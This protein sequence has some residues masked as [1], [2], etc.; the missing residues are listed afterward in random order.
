[1]IIVESTDLDKAHIKASL[2]NDEL[3]EIKYTD[4]MQHQRAIHTMNIC[5]L[6]QNL[7]AY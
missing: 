1:M 6:M 3:F 5:H 4:E 7:S 2:I